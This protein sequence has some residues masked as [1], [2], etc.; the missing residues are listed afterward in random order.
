MQNLLLLFTILAAI[1]T[2]KQLMSDRI[3]VRGDVDIRLY[4]QDGSVQPLAY[5][6]L[7]VNG[8]KTILAKLLANDYDGE[9]IDAIAFGTGSTAPAV[10]DVA[11][12]AQVLV[13]TATPS[14]PA[15]NSVMFTT[16]MDVYE[17]GTATFQEVG[18]V[19][20]TTRKL[21]SR[22]VINPIMKSTLYKIEV[23]WTISFQ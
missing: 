13:K 22:L 17:G 4:H 10:S 20:H 15:F 3:K 14:Y 12:E 6:N 18:L 11:L 23:D 9:Y 2:I 5:R 21:F 16:V 7:V 1:A 19:S 8:G